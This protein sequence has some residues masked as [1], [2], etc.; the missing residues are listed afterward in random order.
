M[1]V[2]FHTREPSYHI[3]REEYAMYKGFNK[4]FD[5]NKLL[6]LPYYARP[7]YPGEDT[8]WIFSVKTF[9]RPTVVPGG[10]KLA[11]FYPDIR[12]EP[13]PWLVDVL[14]DYD[15]L[16]VVDKQSIN[17]F[18]EKLPDIEVRQ[19]K[20]GVEPILFKTA[21]PYGT[22][23]KRNWIFAGSYYPGREEFA[24][25]IGKR[26]DGVIFGNGWCEKDHTSWARVDIY[27]YEL[28]AEIVKS[29]LTLNY[30]VYAD[31]REAFSTRIYKT[32]VAGGVLFTNQMRGFDDIFKKGEHYIEYESL[33]EME[34]V[35]D[36]VAEYYDI[37]ELVR[38]SRNAKEEVTKNHT[39]YHRGIE[40]IKHLEEY[41]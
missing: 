4:A 37:D 26:S 40:L 39:Y 36:N 10:T 13:Q 6:L 32:M 25:V 7:Y 38:I 16:F 31:V 1:I 11:Y 9:Q 41:K 3:H 21:Y 12:S 22:K 17:Q 19:L 28:A 24:K 23:I 33:S 8:E 27:N 5:D 34:K 14:K 29:V 15:M 18:R 30:N 35:I 20:Q 2:R